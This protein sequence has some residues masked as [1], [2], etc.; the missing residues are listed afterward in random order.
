MINDT[1]RAQPEALQLC[2]AY[3]STNPDRIHP[4]PKAG[5]RDNFTMP[6]IR[7]TSH[8]CP[9]CLKP[10]NSH[11][12]L[13]K[14]IEEAHSQYR[15]Q[16]QAKKLPK[17]RT[18]SPPTRVV[19]LPDSGEAEQQ[20]HASDASSRGFHA[21]YDDVED[22][23]ALLSL[24]VANPLDDAP[25]VAGSGGPD[26]NTRATA[27]RYPE[28]GRPVPF[29]PSLEDH[30]DN[31]RHHKFAVNPLYPFENE[32][33]YN[34]AEL[35]TLQGLSAGVIDNMLKGNCGL[36][37]TLCSSLRSN[38]HLRLKIDRMEDGLGHGSWKKS[39]LSMTWNDQHP[40]NISFWHRDI[41]ACAKWLLRQP[42]YEDQLTY[43]PIRSFNGAGHRVYDEMHTGDWWWDKQVACH[44]FLLLNVLLTIA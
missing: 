2:S 1:S 11:F 36:K 43:A 10:Y 5:T 23:D 25:P 29:V 40:D 26:F 19:S 15:P 44:A 3:P 14:H 24:S 39:E 42:A 32:E 22:P 18:Y 30:Q 33:E 38:Y 41:V 21:N 16:L 27:D 17:P 9:I 7:R 20:C 34:F 12:W 37:D 6:P 8:L 31:A 4:T 28:A 35:V 13:D